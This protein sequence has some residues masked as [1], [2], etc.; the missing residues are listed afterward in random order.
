MVCRACRVSLTGAQGKPGSTLCLGCLLE[1][2]FDPDETGPATPPPDEGHPPMRFAHY[3]VALDGDGLPIEL[4]HGGMGVTYRAVD[5]TLHCPV[6]LK[7]INLDLVAHPRTRARFLR[8]ARAAAG[9][10][11]PH[12]ASVFFYGERGID[13]QP[14]YVMEL[15][16]GET[17][18]S[19]VHRTGNLPTDTVLSIGEQVADALV[20]AEALGLTHRDL[21]PSNLMLV[22]G[23]AINVKII[24]FGLAKA[25]MTD[26]EAAD[27]H[28]TRAE[29]FVGTPAFA[30]PEQFDGNRPIDHRSDFYALGVTLWFALTGKPPFTGRT[31]A[32][33][34]DQQL[35]PLPLSQ[36]KTA[37][38]SA[39][40]VDLL[41]LLLCADPAGRV[42]SAVALTAALRRCRQSIRAIRFRRRAFPALAGIV[43][44]IVL[45]VLVLENSSSWRRRA[46]PHAPTISPPSTSK[47]S[48]AVLPFHPLLP[49]NRDQALELGMADTLIGKLSNSQV[50]VPSLTSVR[51]YDNSEQDPQAAGREL[52]VR[53]VL[54]GNLQKEGD[55]IRVTARLIKVADGTALWTG[56]FDERFTDVFAVQDAISQKVVD[57]L[58]LRLSGREKDRITKRE[59]DN[60]E[61]YQLYVLGRYHFSKLI[62][63]EVRTSIELFRRAIK[64]DGHY[65]L[66]YAGL[67]EAYRALTI[68]GDQRPK[69]YLPLAKEAAAKALEIDKTLSDPH[70]T[71]AFIH[72]WFDWDWAGAER[73]AKRAI[74]LN[75]NSAFA[76]LAYAH[77]L[78]LRGRHQEA[79]TE[80][81]KAV[82]LDP[83]SLMM[84]AVDG[85]FLYYAGRDD[86]ARARLQ[87]TLELAPDFWIAHLYLG[88]I[89]VQEGRWAEANV[90][91]GAAR[92]ASH[93]NSLTIAVGGY[94]AALAGDS[95][96]GRAALAE[97]QVL[98]AQRYIPPVTIALVYDGLGQRDETFRWLEKALDEHDVHLS[99]LRADPQW[100]SLR[101]DPRFAALLLGVGLP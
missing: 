75:P 4:G 77:L 15:V 64:L 5:T 100:D 92:E 55:R 48:I 94:A 42:P 85:S 31:L 98:S 101:A 60:V 65:A 1:A 39:P 82:Q 86:E 81:A 22:A 9:L 14:F 51:K 41:R 56:T 37:R 83:A 47:N 59:T 18:A 17:L 40:V 20:A 26:T 53:S 87:K 89:L 6:A 97:L 35:G 25:A 32:E 78:A 36:L 46:F 50:V 28:R 58:A 49:G 27:P 13:G 33:I 67:A 38:V 72:F 11:H 99:Y 73:E 74:E 3:E 95:I 10:R 54:E 24:D 84:N 7:V 34:Y 69:D 66:A 57:A 71:L 76:H 8:E 16:E 21:K 44:T 96:N 29:A 88:K 63:P 80:G 93:G 19:C 91:L 2:G 68:T 79:V 61:A 23:E 52:G 12:V 62:P 45:T 90:E 70:A 30:S 43:L